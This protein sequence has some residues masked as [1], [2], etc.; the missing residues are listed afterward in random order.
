MPS[1]LGVRVTTDSSQISWIFFAK[2][3][4]FEFQTTPLTFQI[5]ISESN[6]IL[7]LAFEQSCFLPFL[8]QGNL[9]KI[10]AA[11]FN[12]LTKARIT[13]WAKIIKPSSQTKGTSAESFD[14]VSV[15]RQRVRFLYNILSLDW[16]DFFGAYRSKVLVKMTKV[17]WKLFDLW[18]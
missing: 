18:D 3:S 10:E 2:V 13:L 15:S 16:V 7:T 6:H 8:I 12:D 17:G 5:F 9:T 14:F 4:N 11:Q 1:F